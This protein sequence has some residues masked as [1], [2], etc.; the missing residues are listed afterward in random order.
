MAIPNSDPLLPKTSVKNNQKSQIFNLSLKNWVLQ[1][2]NYGLGGLCETHFDP[3]GYIEGV[4]L[5]PHPLFQRL[6]KQ[7]DMAATVMGWLEDVEAGGDTAFAPGPGM[8]NVVVKP[9]KGSAAFWYDLDRKGYRDR[10][11]LHGGC[12]ILKGSKWI[13]N[14]W[15]HFFDQFRYLPCAIKPDMEFFPPFNNYY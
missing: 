11:L 5:P 6:K 8:N 7:G 2:T 15:I 4:E 3:H 14:K 1:V 12:P 9:E 13:L 10:R